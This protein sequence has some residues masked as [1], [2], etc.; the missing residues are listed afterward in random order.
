VTSAEGQS[1]ELPR[2]LRSLRVEGWP[3]RRV[4]QRDLAQALGVS[5]PSISAW[6][7]TSRLT[8]PPRDRLDDYATFFATERSVADRSGRLLDLADLTSEERARREELLEELRDLRT[9]TQNNVPVATPAAP[10]ARDPFA[11][12][13]WRFPPGQNITIVGSALPKTHLKQVHYSDPDAPDYVELYKYADLDALIELFGHLRAA[14][15]VSDV[16]IRTPSEL[17][18]DDAATHLVLLGGVDWNTI[19]ADLLRRQDLP[20]RQQARESDTTPF[21]F[22]VTEGERKRLFTPVLTKVG[23]NEHLLEDIAHFYRAPSPFNKKRTVT[24]CNGMYQRGTL[25]AVR[26]LTDAMFRDRNNNYARDRFAGMSEFSILSRVLIVSGNVITPDWSSA[27]VR[28]HEW[29]VE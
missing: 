27:E 29:S 28:L 23:E 4:A 19:T 12:T 20:V 25:G 1:F 5:E 21:G 16:H 8:V 14:N 2:R 7:N 13:L 26:T 22:E 24:I 10:S 15:P 9:R 17:Q 18:A 3:G 6:E 11:A